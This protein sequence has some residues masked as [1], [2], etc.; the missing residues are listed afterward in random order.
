ML[1]KRL[2]DEDSSL[3]VCYHTRKSRL[4]AQKQAL[5]YALM[6]RVWRRSARTLLSWLTRPR[7]H[8]KRGQRDAMLLG[9]RDFVAGRWGPALAAARL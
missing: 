8:H 6:L 1:N 2:R 5:G 4:F 3:I 9:L 7:C